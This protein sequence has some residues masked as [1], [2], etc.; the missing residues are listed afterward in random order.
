MYKYKTVRTLLLA[1]ML[2]GL[3]SACGGDKLPDLVQLPAQKPAAVM[4][5]NVAVL[6]VESG[7]LLEAQDVL[8]LGDKISGIGPT[9][10]L[11]QPTDAQVIDGSGATLLPGL[12]DMHSHIGNASAPRWVGEFPDPARNMQAYLYSGVTT[13][14]DAAGLA[15]KAFELRDQANSGELLGPRVYA[16]GP[17]FTAKGGHPAAVMEKFAPWWIRWYL[18][19]RYTRQVETADEARA[20]VREV[21]GMGADAIKVA[22]DRI[23]ESSPRIKP[24]VLKAVVDEARQNKLR[25]VAHIGT[26]QEAI[27]AAD[28]GVT[29]WVHG[30]YQ[31]RIPDDQIKKLA[32]YKIPMVA[33][34]V[35]FEGY[36]LLGRGAREPTPLERETVSAKVLAAF[37]NVPQSD[38]AD[39]FR[40]YLE[41]LYAQRQNSRDNVRRLHEAGV[42]IFAGSDTQSGVFPGAGLHRELQLLQEA[43][44]TPAQVI[45][46]ATVEAAR[47]L[48][49]GK[50]PAYGVIKPGKQ[51]D[52]LLV[53]GNPLQ[54]LKA[55]AQIRSV[56]KGGVP[57]ERRAFS[58]QP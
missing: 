25:T 43:G 53:E 37:D 50:E 35:V 23:P 45:K 32:S 2:G 48:A 44:M 52:L 6:D 42:T 57:L 22:V 38:D 33:T 26:T 12:I 46:A 47:Y 20:A 19:P 8:T 7:K 56:I 51:A 9:G 34:I 24:E 21:A 18:I 54:D 58:P 39:Y 1:A 10:K 11:E 36:A 41:N 28:A 31:E 14:F 15:P 27:E 3:L 16:T 40:P 29:L 49:D 4:I 17:I 5:K 55:L 13:V 30:V